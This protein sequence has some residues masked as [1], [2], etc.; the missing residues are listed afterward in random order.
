MRPTSPPSPRFGRRDWTGDAV[1]AIV[2]GLTAAVSVLLPWANTET[3]GSWNPS[4][5]QAE[6]IKSVLVTFWG[7]PALALA[8]AAVG[9]GVAMLALGPRR[10]AGWL[11]AIVSLAGLGLVLVAGDGI[12]AAYGFSTTGGIGGI[13]CLLAGLALIPIGFAS[14]CVAW[15]LHRPTS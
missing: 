6:G 4:F 1:L 5:R 7:P 15:V 12:G 8:L 14:A 10:H 2:A 3:G 13:V 11:G 9:A